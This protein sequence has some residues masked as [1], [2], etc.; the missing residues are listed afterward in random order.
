MLSNSSPTFPIAPGEWATAKG[1]P[2]NCNIDYSIETE[3]VFISNALW[4][5]ANET[6]TKIYREHLDMYLSDINVSED[7]LQCAELHCDKHVSTICQLH[8]NIL[9]YC[10]KATVKAI[11]RSK[12]VCK[13]KRRTIIPGWTD[14]HSIARDQSLFWHSIWI[15]NDKP[16]TGSVSE[17]MRYTRSKYNYLVR[18]LKRSRDLQ[19]RCA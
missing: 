2:W 5:H 3:S 12:P 17:I 1:T 18:S 16:E 9:E 10:I 8:Y 6:Q 11:S 19:I 13:S 15:D 14:Q 7:L 4:S